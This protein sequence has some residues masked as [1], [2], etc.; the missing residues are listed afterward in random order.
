M[1]EDDYRHLIYNLTMK[2]AKTLSKLNPEM[3]FCYVSGKATDSSE[4]GRSMWARVKGKTENDLMK[5]PFKQVFAF[6]PGYMQP[7]KGL[8]NTLT[9]YKFFALLYP[10]LRLVFLS[11]ACTLKDVGIAM[12]N[13]ATR[14]YPKPVLE[15]NDIVAAA[16]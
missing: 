11:G 1:K 3:T 6:R 10:L 5:L 9:L 14:G 15:V 2:F 8:K 16:K 4:H 7:T 12:I 13:V